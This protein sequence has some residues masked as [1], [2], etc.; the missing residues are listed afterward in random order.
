[1]AADSDSPD[2]DRRQG[3]PGRLLGAWRALLGRG[4][5]DGGNGQTLPSAARASE[6]PQAALIE[7]LIGG[8]PGPAI[9][10][11]REARVIAFNEAA[12]SLAPA[13]RVGE[14]ALITLRMPELVDAIRR[15]GRR[16]ESQRVEFFERVP[17][18]RWFEAFVKPVTLPGRR[19]PLQ[20]S[21]NDLQ[22]SD[23]AAPGRGNARRL[24]RQCQ[25][26]TAHAARRAFRVYR[27]PARPG[28][29]RRRRAREIPW[30]HAAA[31]DPDGA[32]DRRSAVAVAHRAQRPFA[33]EYAAR[34]GSGGAPG[35]RRAADI[36]A[37]PRGR[38]QESRCRR[39]PSSSM[40]TATS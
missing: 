18:D 13:L 32:V 40:A 5:N 6:H 37:R 25:P 34:S 14:P 9:V 19:F 33:A 4:G 20:Y 16:R 7:A 29:E 27:N 1:M 35:R 21:A 24:R 3:K 30:H 26:R 12:T 23:A 38:D 39:T 17:L 11:D 22:R 2:D 10:L 8:L 36:G 15:A 31:G 28:Q